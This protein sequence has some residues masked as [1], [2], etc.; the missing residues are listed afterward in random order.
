MQTTNLAPRSKR[1][2]A[3]LRGRGGTQFRRSWTAGL[4][5]ILAGVAGCSTETG[6]P[7]TAPPVRPAKLLEVAA[8]DNVLTIHLP[9]VIEASETV[10]LAFQTPG[11]L[12]S[13]SVREGER[14]A[15]GKEI[16]RLDQR[17]QQADLATAR[18][19]FDAAESDFRR[20][21]KLVAGGVVSRAEHQRRRTRRDVAKASLDAARKHLDDTV[22][23][24]PFAGI[25]AAV[26]VKAFQNVGAQQ[27]VATLQT[28]GAAEAVVQVPATLV[29]NSRR[30][31]PLETV[32]VLDAAPGAPIPATLHS[33]AARA[34]PAAQTFELRFAFTP[35]EGVVILPGMTGNLRATLA[36]A[37]EDGV[38]RVSVPIAAILSDAEA[39]YVWVVDLDSMTVS[40]RRV[41]LG[42]GVG[43]TLPVERGLSAGETIVAAGVSYL[44]EGM[45]VRRYRP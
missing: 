39:R 3:G 5:G 27:S 35:P 15:E 18:A 42:N 2:P 34:D 29:A 23:R 9:A 33:T 6:A 22:L 38:T 1:P 17:D 43:E 36:V 8:V 41:V 25:V 24:S 37:T 11:V 44:H 45:R 31:T 32:V 30:I 4:A 10:E 16:A 13:I 21:D 12:A 20:V 14:V 7:G 40:K 19:N 26:H 28:T